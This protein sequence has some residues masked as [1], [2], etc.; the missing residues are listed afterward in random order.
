MVPRSKSDSEEDTIV[1]IEIVAA[2]LRQQ[3]KKLDEHIKTLR[4]QRAQSLEEID[5]GGPR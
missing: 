1:S 2:N 5:D 3:I 4:E